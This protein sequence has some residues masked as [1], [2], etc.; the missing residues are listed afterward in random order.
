MAPIYSDANSACDSNQLVMEI[1]KKCAAKHNLVCLLHEKPFAGITGSGKHNNYSLSTDTGKNLFHP[2]KTPMQNAQFL[3]FLAAFVKGVDEYQDWLRCTAATAG[4]AVAAAGGPSIAESL[5]AHAA[6]SGFAAT[7]AGRS[8]QSRVVDP[9]TA[10]AAAGDRGHAR[11]GVR[12]EFNRCLTSAGASVARACRNHSTRAYCKTK[13]IVRLIDC[14]YAIKLKNAA[15][16]AAGAHRVAARA[17]SAYKQ[18][19]SK[20]K[21]TTRCDGCP[22]KCSVLE[23]IDRSAACRKSAH[24]KIICCDVAIADDAE[25]SVEPFSCIISLA[26]ECN[27]RHADCG[28]I[29]VF[30]IEIGTLTIATNRP[31]L[32]CPRIHDSE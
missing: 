22:P 13:R 24:G 10:R 17:A 20:E 25:S 6:R 18:H 23:N 30:N 12:A 14:I 7:A 15:S 28:I 3:L 2:G 21:S 16:A 32:R 5:G 19:I 31:R 8:V 9:G 27:S 1:M 29:G 26:D 11:A 4:L